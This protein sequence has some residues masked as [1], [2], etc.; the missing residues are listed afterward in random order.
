MRNLANEKSCIK[1]KKKK[2]SADIV[3][4]HSLF[5]ALVS[6]EISLFVRSKDSPTLQ[7]HLTCK[8]KKQK[9]TKTKPKLIN[10]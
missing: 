6:S 3:L 10:K 1:K 2:D 5:I 7:P 8:K 9:Q 4:V